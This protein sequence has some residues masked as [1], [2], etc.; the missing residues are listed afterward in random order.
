MTARINAREAAPDIMKALLALH[1]QVENCGLEHSLIELVKIRASQI[2]GCAYCI[3]KH[4][5]DARQAG[6]RDER[7]LLLPVWREA[8]HVFTPREQA[9]MAWTEV[10]TR[11]DGQPIPDVYFAGLGPHFT[12]AEIVKLTVVIGTINLWN[13]IGVPFGM[14]PDV[15]AA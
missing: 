13:R 5:S 9:A 11:L 6:E 1:Q 10:V 2:N 14:T 8:R 7:M 3:H 15:K 12:E 4:T